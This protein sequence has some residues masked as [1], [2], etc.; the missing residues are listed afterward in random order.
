MVVAVGTPEDV[1]KVSASYTGSF[2]AEVLAT[3][4]APKKLAAKKK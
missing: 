3:N 2:L 1:A 4:R